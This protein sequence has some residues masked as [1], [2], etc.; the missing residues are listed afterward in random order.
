MARE[1]TTQQARGMATAAAATLAAGRPVTAPGI[2]HVTHPESGE[3]LTY[4]P[5]EALP[6]WVAKAFG[7]PGRVSYDVKTSCWEIA[8]PPAK[9]ARS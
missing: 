6:E 5:G 1:D 3:R 2:L 8:D 4:T 7:D 9:P